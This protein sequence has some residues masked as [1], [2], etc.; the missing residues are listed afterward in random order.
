MTNLEF[1]SMVDKLH[2]VK[3][4][5]NEKLLV[6]FGGVTLLAI[7]ITSWKRGQKKG[8]ELLICKSELD[9][10]KA[11]SQDLRDFN[12]ELNT[13]VVGQGQYIQELKRENQDMARRIAEGIEKNNRESQTQN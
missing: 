11:I 4:K 12:E 9:K 7:A 8:R 10:E 1:V 3:F 2:E 6:L 5:K 13:T